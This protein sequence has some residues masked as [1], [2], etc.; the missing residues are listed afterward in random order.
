LKDCVLVL[1]DRSEVAEIGIILG[2]NA[3]SL[4][5][6]VEGGPDGNAD[7]YPK[8]KSEQK[9]L[10]NKI[11]KETHPSLVGE[12]NCASYDVVVVVDSGQFPVTDRVG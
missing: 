5:W 12:R 10:H 1:H 6:M 3:H 2:I 8:N 7:H 4:M 11:R 9:L